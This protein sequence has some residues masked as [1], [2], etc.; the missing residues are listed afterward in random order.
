[1]GSALSK[2]LKSRL[3]VVLTQEGGIFYVFLPGNRVEDSFLS[4]VKSSKMLDLMKKMRRLVENSLDFFLQSLSI[5]LQSLRLLSS[6]PKS[7]LS[8]P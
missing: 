1:M 3:F 8:K 5:F 6:K 2:G 7:L 4:K